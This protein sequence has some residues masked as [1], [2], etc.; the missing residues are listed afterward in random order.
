MRFFRPR[1]YSGE[2]LF[3]RPRYNL[4]QFCNPLPVWAKVAPGRL[5]LIEVADNHLGLVNGAGAEEIAR[6][7]ASRLVA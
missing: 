2:M 3:F 5:E 6:R 4:P 7:L 1:V